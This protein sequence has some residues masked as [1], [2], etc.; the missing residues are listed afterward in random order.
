MSGFDS[1]LH[2]DQLLLELDVLL[3]QSTVGVLQQLLEVH[4]P[5]VSSQ[6][7]AFGDAGLLLERR[8]L[9]DELSR[10]RRRGDVSDGSAESSSGGWA[11]TDLLLN[12]R[13]LVQVPLEERH[14]LLLVLGVGSF[15]DRVVVL[16]KVVQLD[17]EFDDLKYIGKELVSPGGIENRRSR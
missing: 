8:V 15:D 11:S 12:E 1:V 16:A 4:D 17:L 13:E 9:I 6:E 3:D 5:L 2:G 14:L 7:L 10:R